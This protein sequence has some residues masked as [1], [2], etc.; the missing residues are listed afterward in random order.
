MF[1]INAY[2]WMKIIMHQLILWLSINTALRTNVTLSAF[3]IKISNWNIEW[4]TNIST[5]EVLH[6]I[7]A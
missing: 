4:T 5:D 1:V 7:D 6:V 2:A 3:D